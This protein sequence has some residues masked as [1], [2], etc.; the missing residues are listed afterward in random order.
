M[1][2]TVITPDMIGHQSYDGGQPDYIIRYDI[3]KLVINKDT[4]F[5]QPIWKISGPVS[6]DLTRAQPTLQMLDKVKF[7]FAAYLNA[8]NYLKE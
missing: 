7:V 2:V 1:S 4:K 3:A 8:I 5:D 6:F